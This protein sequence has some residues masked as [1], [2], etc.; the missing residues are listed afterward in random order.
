MIAAAYASDLEDF[1][2]ETKPDLWIHG[3]VHEPFDYVIG[4]TRIICNPHGYVQDPY[5]GFNSK[6]VIEVSA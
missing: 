1:I 6:L 3:H 2:I 5:N 4:K